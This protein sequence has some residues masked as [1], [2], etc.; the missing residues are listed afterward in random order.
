M[1]WDQRY[2][3]G[4]QPAL[5]QIARY[6]SSPLWQDLRDFVESAYGVAPLIEYSIC[7]G[8]RGWN[9]KY[10]KGGRALCTLY[11]HEG[12]FTCLVCIGSREAA[13]AE[14]VLT[15]C[16]AYTRNLYEKTSLFNGARWLMIDITGAE[17]LAD[18]KRLL[19]VRMK[20]KQRTD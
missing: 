13:Q 18:V 4:E 9:V 3:R 8:A 16:A 1:T 5:E 6:I 11:P 14:L 7:S 15:V 19:A 12:F 2:A 20:P 17:I 10:K